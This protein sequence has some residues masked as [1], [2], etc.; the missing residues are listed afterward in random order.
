[1]AYAQNDASQY[2]TIPNAIP[3]VLMDI[4]VPWNFVDT[5]KGKRLSAGMSIKLVIE[6]YIR[7]I[8][9]PVFFGIAETTFQAR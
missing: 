1:M 9:K 3:M 2:G 8:N 4:S 7:N 5:T 6:T